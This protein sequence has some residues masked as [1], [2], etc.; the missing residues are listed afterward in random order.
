MRATGTGYGPVGREF[1]ERSGLFHSC[2]AVER[3]I[4]FFGVKEERPG[5]SVEVPPAV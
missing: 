2:Q 3:A 1:D 4:A 5:I